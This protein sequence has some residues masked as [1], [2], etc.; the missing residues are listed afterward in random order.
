VSG[1]FGGSPP[2]ITPCACGIA[3][4]D[5]VIASCDF[6]I[7]SCDFVIASRDFVIAS[8]D[9]VIASRDFVI[10]SRD[11]V[12]RPAATFS[13]RRGKKALKGYGRSQTIS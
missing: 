8:R 1:A 12:I 5:F 2:L 7:A 4:R 9:F 10:A 3:S 6:V 13:P 11:F